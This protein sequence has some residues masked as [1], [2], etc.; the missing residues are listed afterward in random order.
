MWIS[1]FDGTPAEIKIVE[2]PPQRYGKDG[3]DVI[4]IQLIAEGQTLIGPGTPIAVLRER[5]SIDDRALEAVSNGIKQ[6]SA[7]KRTVAEC[8][9]EARE[10]LKKSA[11]PFLVSQYMKRSETKKER[12]AKW[13]PDL[14]REVEE[15]RSQLNTGVKWPNQTTQEYK[16]EVMKVAEN[17]IGKQLKPK[18]RNS[19][20]IKVLCAFSCCFWMDGCPAPRV[21]DFEADIVPKSDSKPRIQQPFPLSEF[22]QL[23]LDYHLDEDIA[24]GKAR[25]LSPTEKCEWASPAFV[26]DQSGKG[27]LGRPV[28]DYRYPNSQTEDHAWPSPDGQRALERATRAAL[29]TTLDCVWGFTQCALTERAQE[30]LTLTTT[31]GLH[32]PLVLVFGPKQGPSIFQGLMDSTFRGVKGPQEEDFHTI[33]ID[34]VHI[35]TERYEGDTEDETVERH[36]EHCSLFLAAARRRKIQFKLEKCQFC[37]ERVKLLGFYVGNS[38]CFVPCPLLFRFVF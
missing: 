22:D 28:R 37:Q 14:A 11:D 12:Q 34:D 30:I 15:A 3:N 7:L 33:F 36:I 19:F 26:V 35:G 1:E 32:R 8:H 29:H 20:L 4:Q 6:R 9:N 18:Q 17:N 27:L 24:L 10:G 25:W 2:G 5:D 23:R 31:R 13:F 21:K 16:N 38:S